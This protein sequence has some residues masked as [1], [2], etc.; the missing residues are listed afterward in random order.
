MFNSTNAKFIVTKDSGNTGGFEEK[1]N[2]A[3]AAGA[4]LIV[5][6][7]KPEH[8]GIDFAAILA[9]IDELCKKV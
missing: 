7:R 4:T 2:A 9:K 3:A 6:K 8:E 1:K 5:I